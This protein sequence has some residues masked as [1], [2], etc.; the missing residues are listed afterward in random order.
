MCKTHFASTLRHLIVGMYASEFEIYDNKKIAIDSNNEVKMYKPEDRIL[1]IVFK[2]KDYPTHMPGNGWTT[3]ER[4]TV[5]RVNCSYFIDFRVEKYSEYDELDDV[6]P[7]VEEKKTYVS[8]ES[9]NY[10]KYESDEIAR[11]VV[12][13][14]MDRIVLK[15]LKME[16][17]MTFDKPMKVHIP[18]IVPKNGGYDYFFYVFN[19]YSKGTGFEINTRFKST[20]EVGAKKRSYNTLLSSQSETEYGYHYV[21]SVKR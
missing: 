12:Q 18:A 14:V 11:V 21:G 9:N 2:G 1:E 4:I 20:K 17:E 5:K 10:N 6:M 13:R 8:D 15:N 3:L 19:T 16:M 7:H